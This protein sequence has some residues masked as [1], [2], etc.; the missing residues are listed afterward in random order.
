MSF[1]IVVT[2]GQE[3]SLDMSNVEQYS[4]LWDGSQAGWVLLRTFRSTSS[5]TVLFGEGGASIRDVRAL[6]AALPKFASLTAQEAWRKLSGRSTAELGEFEQRDSIRI[7]EALKLQG[8][9]VEEVWTN[10]VGYLLFNEST[11]MAL[12]IDENEEL[13]AAVQQKALASGTPV[14]DIET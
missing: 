8:L 1:P 7:V 12:L 9:S 2:P 14:R 5:L 4:Y 13:S 3:R 10:E 11:K 6:R